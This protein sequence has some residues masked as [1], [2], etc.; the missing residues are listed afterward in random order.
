MLVPW[1]AA[2][3]GRWLVAATR[4]SFGFG[5]PWRRRFPSALAVEL[6][7]READAADVCGVAGVVARLR[8]FP[9]GVSPGAVVRV[10]D[11]HEAEEGVGVHCEGSKEN[12]PPPCFKK[13]QRSK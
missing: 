6:A 12:K 2:A 3:G 4:R 9:L 8:E 5:C 11:G 1:G 7:Y 10:A 13:A